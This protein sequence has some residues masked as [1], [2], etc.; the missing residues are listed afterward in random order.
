HIQIS[1]DFS[2]P[3]WAPDLKVLSAAFRKQH[4]DSLERGYA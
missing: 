1:S 2:H 4:G 3:E